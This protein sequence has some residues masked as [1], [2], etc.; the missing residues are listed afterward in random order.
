[1]KGHVI[2]PPEVEAAAVVRTT[3]TYPSKTGPLQRVTIS[4][5]MIHTID[6]Q[7]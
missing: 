7:Y 3:E 1:M 5:H 4:L 2:F 6:N